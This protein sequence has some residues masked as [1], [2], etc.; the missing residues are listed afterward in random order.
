MIIPFFRGHKNVKPETIQQKL[1]F[2]RQNKNNHNFIDNK[3]FEFLFIGYDH[4]DLYLFNG[5]KNLKIKQNETK[6]ML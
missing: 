2:Y 3:M 1:L 5:E 6:I 4:I